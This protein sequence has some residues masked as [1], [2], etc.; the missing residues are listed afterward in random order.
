[1]MDRSLAMFKSC[2]SLPRVTQLS[3]GCLNFSI[4]V[5]EFLRRQSAGGECRLELGW[6]FDLFALAT[7]RL[8]ALLHVAD[9]VVQGQVSQVSEFAHAH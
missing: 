8:V 5:C 7:M 2:K 9:E 3:D 4:R 1:M 6:A